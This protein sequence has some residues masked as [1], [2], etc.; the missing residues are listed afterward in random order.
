M[1]NNLHPSLNWHVIYAELDRWLDEVE[2]HDGQR[3]E[4]ARM[5]SGTELWRTRRVTTARRGGVTPVGRRAGRD[6]R[7]SGMI[8]FRRP[9][10]SSNCRRKSIRVRL[11]PRPA[12][13]RPR[14]VE[15]Q[16]RPSGT[17][18]RSVGG[19]AIPPG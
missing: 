12:R 15:C 8:A 16:M 19:V 5:R 4:P 2:N 14:V 13:L 7:V 9:V 3:E 10:Y 17:G 18:D 6:V 11:V 1:T